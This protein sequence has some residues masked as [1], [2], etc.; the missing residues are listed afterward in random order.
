[1]KVE[2]LLSSKTT[3]TNKQF[4]RKQKISDTNTKK[5]TKE[6]TILFYH[7]VNF[8][9]FRRVRPVFVHQLL[10]SNSSKTFYMHKLTKN[11]FIF[12]PKCSDF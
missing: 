9:L 12:S 5:K 11:I 4:K 1:M 7:T 10:N 6:K 2:K 3:K 8:A